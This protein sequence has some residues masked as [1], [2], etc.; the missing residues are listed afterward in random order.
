MRI[1]WYSPLDTGRTEIARYSASLRPYLERAFFVEH[2]SDAAAI[3]ER[4]PEPDGGEPM[5]PIPIYNIGNSA[6]HCD[7]LR[8][9]LEI[10]GIIILHDSSL[11]ELSMSYAKQ[12]NSIRV[13]E[14]VQRQ[15]GVDAASAFDAMFRGPS[16]R[17]S[18]QDQTQYDAFVSRWQLF[19]W[20]VSNALGVVVHSRHARALAEQFYPG[21][22][23]QLDLPYESTTAEARVD[24]GEGPLR[25]V[26]CGHAGPNRRLHQL[27]DAWSGITNP[28]ALELALYGHIDKAQ[29]LLSHA[30]ALGLGDAVELHGFV[31]EAA[32][33]RGLAGSQL[34]VNL[35]YPTVGEASASQL[36]Y[37]SCGLPTL[38]T[39]VGWYAELP[40]DTVFKVS[41]GNET[42]DITSVL[43]ALAAG[44]LPLGDMGERAR[45]Y[46][47]DRHRPSAYVDGLAGF[48]GQVAEKRFIESVFDERL[49]RIMADLCEDVH[50]SRLF[51]D[52]LADLSLMVEPPS[53]L[54]ANDNK[55]D[56]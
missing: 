26:F 16:Y 54:H 48:V 25:M 50:D 4:A 38:V 39:D 35:R 2:W 21:P 49:L 47:A 31:D 45:H 12:G 42:A 6:E 36:R 28:G 33:Q 15:W 20:V 1:H 51:V 43:E 56:S 9:A 13:K 5:A 46:V 3:S 7:I 34:A 44:T 29:A 10:P 27:M 22:L 37:M 55:L 24:S 14:L 11:L 18:G 53:F 40:D 8:L 32:L 17:W 30:K 23:I 19:Q 52:T 41:P